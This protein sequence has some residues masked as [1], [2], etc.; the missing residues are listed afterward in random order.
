MG[1]GWGVTLAALEASG[2][3]AT[4]LDISPKTLTMLDH[5]REGRSLIE[6]DLT[7]PWPSSFTPFDA[8]L[9]LDVVEHLDDDRAAVARLKELVKPGGVLVVSV[10]ALPELFSEFDRIQGDGGGICPTRFAR[11]S[12]KISLT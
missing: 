12:I 11:C 5:E 9:A 1:C 2:Y 10:P 8:V 6:A 3:N 7:R 4:G